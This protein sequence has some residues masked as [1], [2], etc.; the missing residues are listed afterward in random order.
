MLLKKCRKMEDGKKIGLRTAHVKILG[1]PTPTRP[2]QPTWANGWVGEQPIDLNRPI[3]PIRPFRLQ[4]ACGCGRPSI[5]TLAVYV[6]LLYCGGCFKKIFFLKKME[7]GKEIFYSLFSAFHLFISLR[8]LGDFSRFRRSFHRHSNPKCPR[9]PSPGAT[10]S[11]RWDP[12]K[13]PTSYWSRQRQSRG[14]ASRT[15]SR[16][17]RSTRCTCQRRSSRAG[18]YDGARESRESG[19]AQCRGASPWRWSGARRGRWNPPRLPLWKEIPTQINTDTMI[20]SKPLND[21]EIRPKLEWESPV[22]IWGREKSLPFRMLEN[23]H[24]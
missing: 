7:V 2:L 8:N 13:T 10:S 19:G 5:L 11:D 3:S 23:G 16:P 9:S 12:P 18:P 21:G 20:I 15:P 1:P 22:G 4:W 14:L 6:W 17:H 24:Q